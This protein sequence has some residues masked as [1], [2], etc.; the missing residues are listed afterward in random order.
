M[1]TILTATA[2]TALLLASTTLLRHPAPAPASPPPTLPTPAPLP[3]AASVPA[4]VE[5]GL[6]WLAEA[7]L[8]GGAWGAG[9]FDHQQVR[10]PHAGNGDPATTA[11]AAMALLQAGSTL[12]AGPYHRH[13]RGALDYLL[14]AVEAAPENGPV[15]T[16][17]T[18]TQPQRKL[19]QHIDLSM[20]ARFLAKTLPLTQP[21]PQLE[22]RV[23]A[24]L[25]KCLRKLEQ[26]QA[27][28]G[29]WQDQ[30]W[31]PVLQSAMAN[32]A[33]EQAQ[34]AGRP[35]DDAVLQRAKAYQRRNVDAATGAVRTEAAAGISLYAI[36]SSQR[37][38]APEARAA[39]ERLQEA[40]ERGLV[41]ADA[42]VSEESLAKAGVSRDV[43]AQLAG[44]Y[45]QHEATAAMLQD[46]TVLAGFGNNG[47]EEFLSYMMAGEALAVAGGDDWTAW[48]GK[49]SQRLMK[50]QNPDGSWSGHHCITSPVFCTA[51]VILALTADRG[52]A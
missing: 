42:E 34:A 30:A 19:G 14:G 26:A 48:Q 15:L 52:V 25:D 2:L 29:S 50:I 28:D 37:A 33:L 46:E 3:D 31:A 24:A 51:A 18:G 40:K 23:A 44:A 21:N 12:E 47:G 32:A 36:S 13:V 7:Q 41:E 17:V 27:T 35:V 5:R 49:M 6:A 16:G 10:D 9:A 38:A 39:L 1:K 22:D 4:F 20:T 45:R 43:A 8:P 11:F